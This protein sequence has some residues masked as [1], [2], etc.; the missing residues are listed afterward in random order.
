MPMP[1]PNPD[2]VI[3]VEQLA[4][5]CLSLFKTNKSKHPVPVPL[6]NEQRLALYRPHRPAQFANTTFQ[7]SLPPKVGLVA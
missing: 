5:T 3:T 4:L 6:T 7:F 2:D 1:T